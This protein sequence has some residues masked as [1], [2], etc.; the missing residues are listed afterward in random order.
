MSPSLVVLPIL[1]PLITGALLP[2]FRF[3]ERKCRNIYVE[4]VTLINSVMILILLYH[5]PGIAYRAINLAG[6]LEVTFKIDGLSCLFAGLIAFLWPFATLYAFEYMEHLGKENTFFAFYTMTF[7]VTTGIAFAGNLMTLYMFYEM[8]TLVTLPLVMAGMSREAIL[9]GRKY[10]FYSIGGAAFAFIGFIFIFTYGNTMNFVPGGVLL[11]QSL[12]DKAGLLRLVYVLAVLGFGVKAA[13]F[14]FHGWLPAAS[15][16]PTPVTALL[17]AVAVVKAGAFA[18]IRITYYSYGTDFL[19]GTWAQYVILGFAAAT[20]L[21]GSARAVKEPHLKRRLAYSTVSNLSYIVF[22]AALMTPAGLAGG[23]SHM[24]FHAFIKITLFY[25]AGAVLVGTHRQYVR[26]LDGLGKKMPVVFA[27]F[28]VGSLALTGIPGF[29]GFI[30]KWNLCTA[31]VKEGNAMALT[32]IAALLISA[33]LTAVYL[34][35]TIIR[36]YY[37]G[38]DF[39]YAAL[40]SV[41][42]PGMLMKIPLT[43][44]SLFIIVMGIYSVP[45]MQFLEKIASGWI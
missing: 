34:F 36:A 23:L 19:R 27:A 38:K 44:F 35:T 17:H 4:L 37:P 41:H 25:C 3:R 8:L 32:G 26:E 11:G 12:G 18:I 6:N 45:L 42:D 7:G 10:V 40:D 13:V 2:L 22:G 33:L 9:A 21:F 16:A 28:T 24:I 20:I 39:D 5:H 1:F 15:I 30:S 43:V 29:P 31:A 14:P